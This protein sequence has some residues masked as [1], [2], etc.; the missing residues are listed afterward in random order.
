MIKKTPNKSNLL[1]VFCAILAKR[2]YIIL[3]NLTKL[4]KF[5]ENFKGGSFSSFFSAE[6][7]WLMTQANIQAIPNSSAAN[8]TPIKTPSIIIFSSPINLLKFLH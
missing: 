5:V 3:F 4:A 1:G 7:S 8:T 6:G 2:D